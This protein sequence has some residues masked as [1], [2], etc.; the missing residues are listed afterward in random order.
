[1]VN[2]F[3]YNI[4]IGYNVLNFITF[5]RSYDEKSTSYFWHLFFG[6]L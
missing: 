2:N 6:S 4:L 1:M 5:R 3:N